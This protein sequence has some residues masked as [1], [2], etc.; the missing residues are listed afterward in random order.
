MHLTREIKKA[1]TSIGAFSLSDYIFHNESLS[2]SYYSASFLPKPATNPTQICPN[3]LRFCY[4]SVQT[5]YG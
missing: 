3:L 4:E 5:C 1:P 2:R